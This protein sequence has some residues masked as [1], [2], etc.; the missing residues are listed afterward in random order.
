M[1]Y[2]AKEVDDLIKNFEKSAERQIANK[3][4]AVRLRAAERDLLVVAEKSRDLCYK[5]LK[6]DRE[7]LQNVFGGTCERF[8]RFKQVLD[9]VEFSDMH[10]TDQRWSHL[11]DVIDSIEQVLKDL[12]SFKPWTIG[13]QAPEKIEY[14][15][16]Q[17]RF[18]PGERVKLM[19]EMTG[20]EATSFTVSPA[21]PEGLTLHPNSGE[22]KG[23]LRPDVEVD[24]TTYLI[25]GENGAGEATVELTFGVKVPPP[26][27]LAY[28]GVPESIF[29]CEAIAWE[30]ETTGGPV[31]AWSV[32]PDLPEGLSLNSAGTVC[33]SAVDT[34]AS[35]EYTITATNSSGEASAKITFE[36]MVAP[37]VSLTYP[38]ASDSY[39]LGGVIYLTPHVTMKT[40]AR[41]RSA[42]LWKGLQ[43]NVLQKK[44]PV[45]TTMPKMTYSVEPALPEGL[46]LVPKTGVITGKPTVPTEEIEYKVTVRNES[47]E[48]GTELPLAILL[49]PPTDLSYPQA[50]GSYFT[51]D[52]VSLSP[53]VEGLVAEWIVEPALPEGLELDPAQGTIAG[54]PTAPVPEGTWKITAKNAEGEATTEL[55]FTV[56]H[57]PPSNFNY[58]EASAL[59]PLLRKMSLEPRVDGHVAEFSVQPELPAGL[60]LDPKTG[61]ISGMP[62]A[63]SEETKYEVTARNDTGAATT[64]VSFAVQ[65]MPPAELDYPRIDDLYEVNE[66]VLLEPEV[67]GGATSWTVEPALPEG[68]ALDGDTGQITGAPKVTAEEASY[69][70][71]ASN[72]AGGTSV[73]LT[74]AVTAP[75]PTGLSYPAVDDVV[76]GEEVLLEAELEVGVCSTFSVDPALP[77][78]LALDPKSG[79]I[80]GVPTAE[81]DLTT[82]KVTA[83]N[84]AGSTDCQL[85][86][87]C[88]EPVEVEPV[89]Q[90]FVTMIE[91][92]T[93]LAEMVEEP[94]KSKQMSDWMVWMVH[95]AWLNDPTL[96]DFNFNNLQMPL[97]HYEPRVAPKLMEAMSRNTH[98]VSLQLVNSNLQKPQ[99]HQLAQSL[100]TN[101]ALRVLNI[102]S[103]NV[104]S[105]SIKACAQ[106]LQENPD[107][108]LETWRFNGQKHVGQYFGRPVEEALA[109]L[110]EKNMRI[111]KLGFACNDPHWRL[112]IDRSIMRNIDVQRRRRKRSVCGDL[113]EDVAAEEKPLSKI[114]LMAPPEKAVWEVFEDDDEKFS[115]VRSYMA[116]NKTFPK[117]EQL[118]SFA[119]SSGKPLKYSEVAPLVKDF[120]T[121]LFNAAVGTEVTATDT[122][123][124]EFVGEMRAW[125]EKNQN[126]S[127]DIWPSAVQRFNFTINKHPL[128]EVSGEFSDWLEGNSF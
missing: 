87:S 65:L 106:A 125:E 93:D 28:K 94:V 96:T 2:T 32:T 35:K 38:Q 127:L 126:W 52:P 107:S 99:G 70:V 76:V 118:Q 86:F 67:E 54:I 88:S 91:G 42:E 4:S 103:N 27:S 108:D 33:G 119:R 9:S 6:G 18:A 116:K 14:Q 97:P 41:R 58:P 56:Q 69:V 11:K 46:V 1:S 123:G 17:R 72:E 89:S 22:I 48:T 57:A 62:T 51:G 49:I 63:N 84:I 7:L 79:T 30:P 44:A 111:T 59:Y 64:T 80:S 68:M 104:D 105:D 122:Y 114:M 3:G 98:I 101:T 16:C 43:R 83:T 29:T 112:I 20:G 12:G 100:K 45:V 102:E 109:E 24:E 82:Y 8:H 47:G 21:L 13:T 60:T 40:S 120:Q 53:E 117:K 36:V 10:A 23:V 39:P 115:L 5:A 26:E 31:K 71:T 15:R 95:R 19:P 73:V 37:P 92:I 81:V 55:K 77:E 74:F 85:E 50:A 78:G 124:S 113:I 61:I 128:V 66:D 75:P 25:K 110:M 34:A 90:G 121:R